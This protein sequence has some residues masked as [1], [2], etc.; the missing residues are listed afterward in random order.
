MSLG[1][2]FQNSRTPRVIVGEKTLFSLPDLLR[3]A[4]TG[5]ICL[6]AGG[7]S[8]DRISI[9]GELLSELSR[10]GIRVELFRH[11]GEPSPESVD[12]AV[13]LIRGHALQAVL[14]VG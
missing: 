13:E 4:G 10:H 12:R 2:R 6:V 14:G 1:R 8:F 7:S 9:S 3:E 5:S 11:S